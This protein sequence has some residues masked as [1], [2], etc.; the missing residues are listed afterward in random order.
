MR[1]IA[2]AAL[3]WACYRVADFGTAIGL[4]IAKPAKAAGDWLDKQA[5]RP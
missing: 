4:M 2:C 5:R 1:R 3:A